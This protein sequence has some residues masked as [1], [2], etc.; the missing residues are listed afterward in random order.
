MRALAFAAA[1]VLLAL[2]GAAALLAAD[3]RG[4][5]RAL[6][7]GETTSATRVPY[8]LAERALGLEDDLAARRAIELYRRTIGV[9]QRLDNSAQVQSLRGRAESALAEIARGSN[10][11]RASQAETLL[12]V[13]VFTDLA[14]SDNP[15]QA[16]TGPALDQVL[17]SVANFQNA[18]RTDPDNLAAKYDLELVIRT[19]AAQGTRVGAAQG[20]GASSGRRGAGGGI[21]GEG[22]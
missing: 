22:Y 17:E 2:A 3:V 18:V 13:L 1:F 5:Q 11:A 9:E 16:P 19:L 15:F 14:P 7:T 8:S 21:P 12:G 10:R 20:G 4:W 6:D